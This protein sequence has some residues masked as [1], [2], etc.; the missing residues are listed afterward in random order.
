MK[1]RIQSIKRMKRELKTVEKMIYIFCENKHDNKQL[2]AEC[3]ALLD[4]V[5]KRLDNC[6]LYEDK[7]VCV[8]CK[9]HCYRKAEREA[10][11]EI[12]RY[13]GPKMIYRHPIL[14]IWHIIDSK[15]R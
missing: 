9:I 14:A 1:N 11:C 5:K 2:C 15:I 13:S 12:M 3:S 8:D 10:I 4:Y 6:P 7:P